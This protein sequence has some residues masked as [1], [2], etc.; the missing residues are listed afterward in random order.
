MVDVARVVQLFKNYLIPCF[1]SMDS[2]V[3]GIIAIWIVI[4]LFNLNRVFEEMLICGYVVLIYQLNT[5]FKY[6]TEFFPF[7]LYKNNNNSAVSLEE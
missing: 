3:S 7:V 2:L 1:L 5:I 6:S 4:S